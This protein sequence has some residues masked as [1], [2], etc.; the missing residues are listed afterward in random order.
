MAIENTIA[1]ILILLV[2][3]IISSLPLYFAVSFLG[4]RTSILR[5]FIVMLIVAGTSI[6]IQLFLPIWG[7]LVSWIV[8]IWIFHEFFRLK[9]LK[10][11]FAWILWIVFIFILTFITGLIGLGSLLIF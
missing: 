8:M 11:I 7:V 10:A 5:T 1:N 6:I 9:W 3:I 4:G 2:I